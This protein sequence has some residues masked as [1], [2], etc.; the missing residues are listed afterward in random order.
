MWTGEFDAGLVPAARHR[1]TW[2]QVTRLLEQAKGA[3][4]E[5][6]A[7]DE[8]PVRWH[9]TADRARG[10]ARHRRFGARPRMRSGL[11]DNAG[12]HA[13]TASHGTR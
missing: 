10:Q 11:R 5:D 2:R 9:Q 3:L 13:P 7:A 8:D 12:R 1:Y 4:R 6:L